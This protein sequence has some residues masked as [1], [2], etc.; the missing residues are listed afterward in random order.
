VSIN[1]APLNLQS[2]M[3]PLV[4]D[5]SLIQPFKYWCEGVQQGGSYNN[6]LY[7]CLRSFSQDERLKAY[8][9]AFEQSEQGIAVCISVSPRG[10]TVWL[11]L[12]SVKQANKAVEQNLL[13]T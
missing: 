11:N 6:E 9:V 13:V 8:E 4:T 7:T 5:E 10:Y 1:L 2:M 3:L 12:R